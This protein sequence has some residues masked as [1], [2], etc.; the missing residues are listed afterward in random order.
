M[1]KRYLLATVMMG[2]VL[3]FGS[4]TW[5]GEASVFDSTQGILIRV[6]TTGTAAPYSAYLE[7]RDDEGALLTCADFGVTKLAN[8][9]PAPVQPVCQDGKFL[10]HGPSNNP[11]NPLTSPD[12]SMSFDS[13]IVIAYQTGI[14][15]VVC[16]D[17][18]DMTGD[19]VPDPHVMKFTVAEKGVT[20]P[21][22]CTYTYSGWGTCQANGTQSR[23]YTATPEGCTGTPVTS[24]TCTPPCTGF[25]YSDWG[26]CQANGTQ[27]RTVISTTPAVCTGG[28]TPVTSQTC[29][30]PPTNG[31]PDLT[32]TA[33][34]GIPSSY[35]EGSTYNL[36]L[37]V[38][39]KGDASSGPWTLT[40][41][42][43][44]TYKPGGVALFTQS[45]ASLNPGQSYS[46]TIPVRPGGLCSP[47]SY[48]YFIVMPD[49]DYRIVEKDEANNKK[50]RESWRVR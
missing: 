11:P 33:M 42:Q 8:G 2:I 41:Y 15:Y 43:N 23:T 14:T 18:R 7:A 3:L 46:T 21:P 4:T 49:S 48:C 5:A 17:N 31:T 6:F 39:N 50:T 35:D 20:P 12:V 1:K 40:I 37:T 19:N 10:L 26:T 28:T 9:D 38:A 22:T 25:T 36:S 47:H 34:S 44:N 13:Q 45:M 27:T 32:T 24:Q 16:T 29:T 30:P